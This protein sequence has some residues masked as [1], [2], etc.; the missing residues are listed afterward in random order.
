MKERRPKRDHSERRQYSTAGVGITS[1]EFVPMTDAERR[2]AIAVLVQLFM[3]LVHGSE[4][5]D[6]AA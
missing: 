5:D 2:K 1:I 3:P 6:V 4:A